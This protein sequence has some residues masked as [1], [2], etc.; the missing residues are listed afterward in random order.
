MNRVL[1]GKPPSVALARDFVC[2]HLLA[3][4]QSHLVDD[5]RLMVSELATNAVVHAQT[6]FGVC[7]SR[8]P[9]VGAASHP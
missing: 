8:V 2:K 5:V 9:G 7:L 6:P 1:P 3:H 4:H